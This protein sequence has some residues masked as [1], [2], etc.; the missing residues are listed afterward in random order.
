MEKIVGEI[1][2][3]RPLFVLGGKS[4]EDE[5]ERGDVGFSMQFSLTGTRAGNGWYNLPSRSLCGLRGDS[6]IEVNCCDLCKIYN[7]K[8][9]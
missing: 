4:R 8:P 1:V 9:E 2:N 5:S 6:L 3:H 7:E